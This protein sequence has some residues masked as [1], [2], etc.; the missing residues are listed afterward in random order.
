[1]CRRGCCGEKQVYGSG[2]GIVLLFLVDYD[3]GGWCNIG[4]IENVWVL[5]IFDQN[6]RGFV[7]A[8]GFVVG[9]SGFTDQ[10]LG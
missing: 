6:D 1:M 10:G 7:C 2:F 8:E 9:K 5:V 4:D 3:A